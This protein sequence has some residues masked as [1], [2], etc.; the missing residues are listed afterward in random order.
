MNPQEVFCPNDECHARG[1][2]GRSNIGVHSRKERRYICHECK[3]TF[4]ERQGTIFYRLQTDEQT[5]MLVVTLLA[6][7]CP[8]KAIEKG[9]GFHERT[10]KG[11]WQRSGKH[12]QAVHEHVIG[13]SQ[14]DLQQVQADEI[15]G[16]GQGFSC[17]IAM[18]MMVPTRLWLGG[19][20]SPKRNL[21]LIQA[22]ANQI[23]QIALCR[24]MLLAVDG[25][26]SYVKAFRRAFRTPFK[27]EKGG[28][29]RL[30]SWPNIAIVQVVKQRQKGGLRI[31]RR[32]VQGCR[33]MILHLLKITQDGGVINTAYIERLNATFRQR[34]A[35]LARRTRNL[36]QQAETLLDGMF[37]VGTFYNFCDNHHSLRLKLSVGKYGY[38]WVQRTP[39]MAAGL[40]DHRWSVEELFFF[41]V[42][43][44]RWKPPKRRGRPSKALL[45]I[46]IQWC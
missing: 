44:P 37:T 33:Q 39:A 25:L 15:K 38:R 5:V 14:L 18:A 2:T 13:G 45:Q 31:D 11:W 10:I 1:Q 24:E 29:R 26:S 16:K 27:G 8:P 4:T 21:E 46:I 40:T 9:F 35:W 22:L 42:P 17:W 3:K 19:A 30:I 43:P 34:L 6:N 41:K 12:C 28:R 23:R 7:G 20:I 32:I 36:A